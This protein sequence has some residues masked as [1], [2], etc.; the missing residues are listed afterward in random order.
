[1]T[2][3]KTIH[4]AGFNAKTY[5]SP[6]NMLLSADVKI[7]RYMY[8]F[9]IVVKPLSKFIFF[10]FFLKLTKMDLDTFLHYSWGTEI[11]YL[12]K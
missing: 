11:A 2:V 6:K 12:A 4:C 8:Y 9:Q 5:L 7:I 1:M 10:A 3:S